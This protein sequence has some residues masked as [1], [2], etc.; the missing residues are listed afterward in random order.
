ML[1]IMA[2]ENMEQWGA[3]VSIEHETVKA[4]IEAYA[5]GIIQLPKLSLKTPK[6]KIR[7]A[8]SF[9]FDVPSP[10]TEHPYTAPMIAEFKGS[11]IP[12]LGG[13]ALVNLPSGLTQRLLCESPAG[14]NALLGHWAA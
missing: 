8:P 7:Y 2:R 10:T 4:V 13:F 1:Q 6:T 9:S 5:Q 14:R 11:R 3:L 12:K